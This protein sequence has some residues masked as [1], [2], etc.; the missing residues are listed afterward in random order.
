[1]TF[2]Q[3]P[4]VEEVPE[5]PQSSKLRATRRAFGS[6]RRSYACHPLFR[7]F[8]RFSTTGVR[9][10]RRAGFVDFASAFSDPDAGA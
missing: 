1:M 5:R 8:E 4:T 6:S 9:D 10:E 2:F 3:T 7:T